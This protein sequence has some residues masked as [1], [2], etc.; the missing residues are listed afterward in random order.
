MDCDEEAMDVCSL[1]RSI[2]SVFSLWA[3]RNY[4]SHIHRVTHDGMQ[5][6]FLAF[7]ISL[8]ICSWKRGTLRPERTLPKAPTLQCWPAF[9]DS[10]PGALPEDC[11]LFKF[12][13][14]PCSSLE[15]DGSSHAERK[16]S[17]SSCTSCIAKG[18][19]LKLEEGVLWV[20]EQHFLLL[21]LRSSSCPDFWTY[22]DPQIYTANL[23][24]ELQEGQV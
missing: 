10:S 20:T 1:P 19:A 11:I 14:C 22:T 24:D 21:P 5:G 3:E 18:P 7:L 23:L 2:D 12:P 13:V 16:G 15:E 9:L 6:Q 8:F 17:L 4:N